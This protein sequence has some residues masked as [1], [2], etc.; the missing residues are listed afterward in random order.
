MLQYLRC[1]RK[2]AEKVAN[3]T[4]PNSPN[5]LTTSL[6]HLNLKDMSQVGQ[7]IDCLRRKERVVDCLHALLAQANENESF[8]SLLLR[9][10]KSI[11]SILACLLTPTP[12]SPQAKEEDEK[13]ILLVL[14]LLHCAL[15]SAELVCQT[16]DF[17]SVN[18]DQKVPFS[19]FISLL[20]YPS[21]FSSSSLSIQ[22]LT[23]QCIMKFIH[24]LPM[25]SYSYQEAEALLSNDETS[26]NHDAILVSIFQPTYLTLPPPTLS[27]FLI[28]MKECLSSSIETSFNLLLMHSLTSL[29]S[30]SSPSESAESRNESVAERYRIY[31]F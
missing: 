28:A 7:I 27:S 15:N 12:S 30:L 25:T 4:I 18:N 17:S 13:I 9:Q 19:L 6:Y 14:N 24:L 11:F 20:K 23:L 21:S 16:I 2:D 29:L 8:G 22:K 5:I 26:A 3:G 1:S 10:D 31:N